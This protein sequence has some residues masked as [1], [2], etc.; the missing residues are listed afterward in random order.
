MTSS[1]ST[2]IQDT[3]F[4]SEQSL[5]DMAEEDALKANGNPA[6]AAEDT[7]Y[8]MPDADLPLFT[9]TVR[10][11]LS[12]INDLL[13]ICRGYMG[14]DDIELVRKAFKQADQAHLGQFRKSGE[15]YICH[16]VAV[17][18]ILAS[19]RLDAQTVQAG[20]M[21]DVLEDTGVT[22]QE[23]A[24][25]FGVVV[26]DLVDGVSKLDKL[27]FSSAEAA[28]AESF[29]KMFMA[30]ARDVRVILIKLADRLHNMRTLEIMRPEKRA[31]IAKETLDIYVPIAHR[32]G[33][34]GVFRELQELS[35]ANRYPMRYAVLYE[36]VLRQRN[37]RRANLERILKDVQNF[38]PEHDIKARILGRDKTIYGIYNKMRQNHQSL[39]DALDIYGFRIVVGTRE[40]CY[41]TLGVL[42]ALYK[43]VHRRFKD[44]IAIPK[45]NGYQGIHTTVIGPHGIPIE[46]QIRT[47][48][49]HRV[50]EYG[51]LSQWLFSR[52]CDANDLQTLTAAWLQQLM[53]IQKDSADSKDFLEN[54][55]IDLFPNRMYAFTPRGRIISLPKGSTP[56]DFAYQVH[57]DIGNHAAG[58]KINGEPVPL[59]TPI[60]NGD[61]VEIV[62]DKKA[63]PSPD[64][65]DFVRSGRARAVIRQFLRN[66]S[67]DEAI[68]AGRRTFEELAEKAGVDIGSTSEESWR[69]LEE[70]LE[71]PDRDGVF[72]SIGLGKDLA[73]AVLHRLLKIDEADVPADLP[74]IRIRGNE[75]VAVELAPCCHPIPGD[76]AIGFSRKGHGLTVHRVECSN[77]RR[78]YE[79]EPSRWLKIHWEEENRLPQY[80]VPLLVKTNDRTGA[81]AMITTH[82][83]KSKSSIIGMNFGT[84]N[85]I[86]ITVLVRDTGHL[87]HVIREIKEISQV[88]QVKRLFE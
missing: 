87:M 60:K 50:A 53:E 39:S 19:W 16:P 8:D 62:T 83:A 9:P 79:H 48:A 29:Q 37:K 63:K 74:E 6:G 38:L 81:L 65:L 68:A 3:L 1:F 56:V 66:S 17:A 24:E 67:Y 42:H 86:S 58:C 44:F 43:P 35:F 71:V 11:K 52:E 22:K 27:R 76:K 85:H 51:I 31:R 12:T 7:P 57:S 34:N 46:F 18:C 23:M 84:E 30:M 73:T 54:I 75:G 5:I 32:L 69:T 4:S 70:E 80:P 41:Q 15:P 28:Q 10:P 13:E 49:M 82:V 21:H 36:H 33:I 77:A 47:E 61:M 59:D 88:Q 40:E 64:W 55:K 25:R 45:L 72:A 26:A 20:L 14:G 78:G 2:D